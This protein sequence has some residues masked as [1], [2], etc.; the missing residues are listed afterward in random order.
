MLY[1]ICLKKYIVI[2]QL[3]NLSGLMCDKDKV[4]KLYGQGETIKHFLPGASQDER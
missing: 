4:Q 1:W 2:F 3:S